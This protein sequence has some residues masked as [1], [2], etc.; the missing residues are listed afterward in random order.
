MPKLKHPSTKAWLIDEVDELFSAWDKPDSPGCA[1]AII[2]DGQLVYGRGYGMANLEYGIQLSTQSV[3]EIGSDSK[4]FTALC[5]VLLA[6][7]GKLALDDEIQKYIPEVRRFENPI[8]LCHLVHHTSGLRDYLSIG[9]LAGFDF[10]NTC[11]ASELISLIARQKGINFLPGTEHLYSNTNYV[12]LAEVVKRVAGITLRDFAE[13]NIFAPLGM[14]NTHFHDNYKEIVPNRALG[15]SQKRNGGFEIAMTNFD[16]VGDKGLYTT[17]D[18]LCLWDVNFYNNALGGYGQDLIEEI[19]TPGKLNNGKTLNYA[20]GLD[21]ISYRGLKVVEHGGSCHGYQSQMAIFPEQRFSV[22]CLSNRDDGNPNRLV[23]QIA[24]IYLA[25]EFTVPVMATAATTEQQLVALPISEI[26]AKIGVY[27]GA[28]GGGIWELT[29][30][31]GKLMLEVQEWGIE[32]FQIFPIEAYRFK[33]ADRGVIIEFEE[34]ALQSPS[35]MRVQTGEQL[36]EVLEKI[37]TVVLTTEELTRYAGN[38]FSEELDAT[39]RLMVKDG[40]IVFCLKGQLPDALKQVN[41][42]VFIYP[43]FCL[44][45]FVFDSQDHVTGFSLS[46]GRVRGIDY[47]RQSPP[48][49]PPQGVTE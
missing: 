19:C 2:R 26:E 33:A 9:Y 24:D 43:S 42:T 31:S 1:I 3:F 4:K 49:R 36:A 14:K 22:I 46:T 25:D 15:Y 37:E 5:L 23:K 18:D 16:M 47:V 28:K 32:P 45:E 12:L 13:Q 41:R 38:F 27:R 20:F 30:Q 21:V 48:E 29:V 34:H 10:N 39:C 8:T 17:I 11:P 6:R 35:A 40:K 44:I 7:Q